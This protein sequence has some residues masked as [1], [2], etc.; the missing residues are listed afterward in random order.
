[1]NL[2]DAARDCLLAAG[3]EEK[4]RLTE[5]VFQAWRRGHLS[6][7]SRDTPRAVPVPGRPARPLLVSPREL[8]RRRLPQGHAALLHAVTHI[9]FN[10]INLAWDAVYRFRALPRGYYADWV[11]VAAEEAVHFRLLR[12][13]L[14]ELGHDYG[15]FPAHNGLWEMAVDTAGDALL[16]MALVP[17]V[18][19]ARGLDVTPGMRQKLGEIGDWQGQ[20]ILDI[21]LRDEIGHVAAGSHWFRQLCAERGLPAENTFRDLIVQH[22]HGQIKPPFYTEARLAAGFSLEELRLL[23]A[24]AAPGPERLTQSA[25]P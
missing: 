23:E 13:R 8:P 2:F 19:E 22:L 3:P 21:V 14:R 11:R 7:E 1:M 15:D 16:R 10:A 20:Q 5:E 18:L 6:L 24:L 12:Q 4:L 9:E 25:M 17:R